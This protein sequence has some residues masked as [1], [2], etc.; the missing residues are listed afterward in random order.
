MT[1]LS[2]DRIETD[3]ETHRA[4]A[5]DTLEALRT[6]M[7]PQTL[8]HDVGAL[9]GLD[10]PE[11]S[12][13]SLGRTVQQHPVAFGLMGSGL[14]LLVARTM[15]PEHSVSGSHPDDHDAAYPSAGLLAKVRD[16]AQT[17]V[18]TAT[19]AASNFGA[20][21]QHYTDHAKDAATRTYHATQD[22]AHGLTHTLERH[23]QAKPLL[24]GG[25]ALA[26]GAV[27]AALLPRTRTENT[28]VGPVRDQVRA[29]A[30]SLG[31]VLQ[32]KANQAAH[33][34]YASAKTV[35]EAEGIVPPSSTSYGVYEGK[36]HDSFAHASSRTIG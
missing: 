34:V 30:S 18:H 29:Q 11:Q 2:P 36:G 10:D 7:S 28:W 26:L 33:A 21:A 20:V 19:D 35:A 5:A 15:T 12:L 13:T 14:A 25:V 24:V 8:L 4:H 17:A 16:G 9:V 6:K 1:R 23:T 32:D 3:I 31:G 27:V 22:R